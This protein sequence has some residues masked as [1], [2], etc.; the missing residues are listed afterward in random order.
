MKTSRVR[1]LA[2]SA[3]LVWVAA[4]SGGKDTGPKKPPPPK[5]PPVAVTLLADES[6]P[7]NNTVTL[8]YLIPA[9]TT[10]AK[11]DELLKFLYR[12]MMTRTEDPPAGASAFLYNAEAQYKT[13]PRSPM[14]SVVLEPGAPGPTFDNKIVK[15]LRV[16]VDEA[17]NHSD[18]GWKLEKKWTTDEQAKS[19]KLTVPHTEMGEDKWSQTGFFNSVM[20]TFT[21]TTNELFEKSPDLLSL[22]YTATWN[23]EEVLRVH[24]DRATWTKI[25]FPA[26]E[27]SIGQQHGRAFL[28]LGFKTGTDKSVSKGTDQRIAGVYKKRV[29]GG[30]KDKPFVSPKLK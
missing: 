6:N 16:Q 23:D 15:E 2:C 20:A 7:Q 3:A 21:D 5:D 9:G 17:L 24:I 26:V 4:C 11:A 14:A 12:Y 19:M 27:E 22:D 1:L 28:E 29:L 30:L 25:D 10:N 13:Q 8:H 18:K